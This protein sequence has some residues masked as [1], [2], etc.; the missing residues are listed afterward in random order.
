MIAERLEQFRTQTLLPLDPIDKKTQAAND[1]IDQMIDSSLA[2]GIDTIP[3]VDLPTIN[4][5]AGLYI[6]FHSLVSALS[7]SAVV[8][9]SLI[10]IISSLGDL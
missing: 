4:S 2:L 9:T 5:R 3:V 1:E 6:Y 7:F 10:L 8:E